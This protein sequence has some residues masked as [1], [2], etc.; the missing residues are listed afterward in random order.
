MTS[1]SSASI[2][3]KDPL[4][5]S[6]SSMDS[7]ATATTASSTSTS[8]ED[9]DAFASL[10]FTANR[11]AT[12]RKRGVRFQDH[13]TL[14][15]LLGKGGFGRVFSCTHKTSRQERACKMIAKSKNTKAVLQEFKLLSELDHPNLIHVYELFEDKK[16]YCIV[17]EQCTGG[18]L[19]D[20]LQTHGPL[21]ESQVAIVVSTVHG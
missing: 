4:Q 15:K 11:F 13:Y 3:D 2:K 10:T 18:D 21:S 19:Y 7:S 12:K 9:E 20:W 6:H 8:S 17:T 1:S 5:E 14:G 16:Y